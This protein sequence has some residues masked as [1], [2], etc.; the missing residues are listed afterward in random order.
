MDP[1]PCWAYED[2]TGPYSTTRTDYYSTTRPPFSMALPNSTTADGGGSSN[3]E[4][5]VGLPVGG[6]LILVLG[7]GLFIGRKRLRLSTLLYSVYYAF[8]YDF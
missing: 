6:L 7:L 4:L 8:V 2:E 1:N 3:R 5:E